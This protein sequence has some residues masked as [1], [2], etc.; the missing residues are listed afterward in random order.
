MLAQVTIDDPERGQRPQ[1]PAPAAKI[2]AVA[3]RTLNRLTGHEVLMA[4]PQELGASVAAT[5][6]AFWPVRSSGVSEL[7]QP[8]PGSSR[9]LSDGTLTCWCARQ[10]SLPGRVV[11][12][13]SHHLARSHRHWADEGRKTDP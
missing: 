9:R 13:L 12:D 6:A 5:G 10:Q 11:A 3:C 2:S 4:A 8:F 1:R 7:P